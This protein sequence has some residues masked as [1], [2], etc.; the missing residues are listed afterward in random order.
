MRPALHMSDAVALELRLELG[1][2]TP[3]GVL[4]ALIGE[5]LP[6]RAVFCDAARQRLQHQH[7]SLVMRHRQAHKI[8]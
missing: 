6:R 8:T 3:G 1:R 4:P 5:D 2:S 7:A